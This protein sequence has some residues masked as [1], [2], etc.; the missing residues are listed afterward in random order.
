M[1][2]VGGGGDMSLGGGGILVSQV[3]YLDYCFNS[4]V[5]NVLV[6][7]IQVRCATGDV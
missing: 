2:G 4:R 7:L 5:E 3:N 1:G 6:L